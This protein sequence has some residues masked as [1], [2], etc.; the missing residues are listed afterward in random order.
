VTATANETAIIDRQGGPME[1]A[2]FRFPAA[3]QKAVQL[4]ALELIR[5][6]ELLPT[7]LAHRQRLAVEA[8]TDKR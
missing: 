3:E 8:G 4:L 5:Q 1:L 7:N 6:V 2:P